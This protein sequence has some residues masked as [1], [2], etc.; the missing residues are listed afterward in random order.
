MRLKDLTTNDVLFAKQNCYFNG[1][2]ICKNERMPIIS[3]NHNHKDPGG[4]F[5]VLNIEKLS[6][7]APLGWAFNEHKTTSE[8]EGASPGADQCMRAWRLSY[9]AILHPERSIVL[10]KLFIIEK[11]V[12]PMPR[13]PNGTRK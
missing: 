11:K 13:N 7:D 9:N 4:T 10:D 12:K 5:V 3:V 1:L 6:I 2:N 8:Q